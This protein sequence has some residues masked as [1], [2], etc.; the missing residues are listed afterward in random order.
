MMT[1]GHTD[2]RTGILVHR[3]SCGV[4]KVETQIKFL[5]MK[6][7]EFGGNIAEQPVYCVVARPGNNMQFYAYFNP[8]K[9]VSRPLPD[10]RLFQPCIF[11]IW[12]DIGLPAAGVLSKNH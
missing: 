1:A 6:V 8:F 11:L 3:N 10:I 4:S 12:P 5:F 7:A 2:L 9:L